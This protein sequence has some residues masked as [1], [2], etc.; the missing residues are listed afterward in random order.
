M[1][2]LIEIRKFIMV[3]KVI[4]I[5]IPKKTH[6]FIINLFVCINIQ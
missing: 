3:I 6:Q 5:K 4:Q 2:N 1:L